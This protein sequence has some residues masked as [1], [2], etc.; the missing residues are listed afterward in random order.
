MLGYRYCSFGQPR[1][2]N[3]CLRSDEEDDESSL[4]SYTQTPEVAASLRSHRFE[5]RDD[6]PGLAFSRDGSQG[7]TPVVHRKKR[8]QIWKM[9]PTR[10]T[11]AES[12]EEEFRPT[13][14]NVKWTPVIPSPVS[15]QTGSQTRE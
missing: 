9:T 5:M 15:Y 6:V 8:R 7:W 10:S 3:Q 13:N 1:L 4:H 14:R 12:S 2:S 11:K